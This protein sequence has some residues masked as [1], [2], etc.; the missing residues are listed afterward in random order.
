M[1]KRLLQTGETMT[2]SGCFEA[3][4]QVKKI[5]N[6]EVAEASRH[7]QREEARAS[8]IRSSP[9]K[10][11]FHFPPLVGGAPPGSRKMPKL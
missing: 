10:E 7:E 9:R 1:F 3:S 5:G 2:R 11:R 4:L 8:V 6:V